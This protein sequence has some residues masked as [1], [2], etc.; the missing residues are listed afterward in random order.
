MADSKWQTTTVVSVSDMHGLYQRHCID[1]PDGDVL[2]VA[3]DIELRHKRDIAALE[4]WLASLPHR[5]KV[6]G[7]GNMDR[8]AYEAGDSLAIAG[9]TV[10]VDK[11]VEVGGLKL[12]ASPWS[13]E[14]AG[15]WQIESEAAGR[16]H[17]SRLL[18]PHL[19]LD[20]LVTH[21]PPAGYGDLTRGSHVGDKE[22]LEAVQALRR[23]PRLWVCGHIHEA[24][25]EYRVPHP[26]APEGILLVNAATY[27]TSKP[28]WEAKAQPRAVALPQAQVV[29]QGDVA[30][31]AAAAAA[32]E[33]AQAYGSGTEGAGVWKAPRDRIVL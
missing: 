30:R 21:T 7:F 26:A 5:H 18:P 15:V 33:A 8:A 29:A 20:V 4:G 2:V 28:G 23:P 14:Y 32:A 25:G 17:W 24:V 19:E 13:P 6:V 22:L 3:G 10:V 1:V 11:V 12:L 9:A 31:A 16:A 27:Y